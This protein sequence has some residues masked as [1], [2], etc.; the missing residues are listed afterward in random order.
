MKY[1]NENKINIIF[2]ISRGFCRFYD[3]N[4]KRGTCGSD[5][6]YYKMINMFIY[7]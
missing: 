6:V 3:G 1:L 5:R 4:M 2:F 7:S